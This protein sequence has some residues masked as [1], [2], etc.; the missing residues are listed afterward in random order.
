[1]AS[2]AKKAKTDE[3]PPAAAEDQ[4]DKQSDGDNGPRSQ[5]ALVTGA[6]LKDYQMEGVEWMISLFS[7]GLSGVSLC[8]QC[9]VYSRRGSR[10]CPFQILADEMGAS[11]YTSLAASSWLTMLCTS[12]GLGKTIQTIA[13]LAHLYE[14]GIKGPFMVV[15]PLS[16]LANWV[17]EFERFTPDVPVLLY[18]GS[19]TERAE[20][21]EQHL[22]LVPVNNKKG[23]LAASTKVKKDQVPVII[24]TYELVINDRAH[25]SKIA[26][27]C[28]CPPL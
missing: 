9:L 26:V 27:C 21:R 28:V 10:D 6:T 15:C 20:K 1:M 25:L 24:T 22:G 23:K 8:H 3:D 7:N 2:S 5:P 13:F 12:P 17:T 14:N 18:H 16:T 4:P 11:L 19:P